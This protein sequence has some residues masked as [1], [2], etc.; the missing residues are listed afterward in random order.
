MKALTLEQLKALEIGEWVYVVDLE[1][2]SGGY[3]HLITPYSNTFCGET[4]DGERHS[5]YICQYSSYGKTWVVY[6]NKEEAECKEKIVKLICEVDDKVFVPWVYEEKSGIDEY[7]ITK[8]HLLKGSIEYQTNI[9]DY[10]YCH[11]LSQF[12]H[13]VLIDYDFNEKWFT[14]RKLAE[15]KLKVLRGG[16]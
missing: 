9:I 4:I 6:R 8:I 7:K 2:K 1:N 3:Y 14:D 15:Q 10:E 5:M 16:L 12:N 13:S 11:P